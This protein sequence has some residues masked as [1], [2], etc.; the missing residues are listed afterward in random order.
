M[1][2][3]NLMG[4]LGNQM[5]QIAAVY[6]YA[7]HHGF[8][9][10]FDFDNCYTPLQGNASVKYK[11]SYFKELNR[12]SGD[13][14]FN[15]SYKEPSFSYKEIIGK[16]DNIILDGYFQSEKYFESVGDEVN[17]I[18]NKFDIKD[19]NRILTYLYGLY[20]G[21]HKDIITVHV[22]R[23]D[24]IVPPNKQEFHTNLG[25]TTDYYQKAMKLFNNNFFL[26]VSDDIQWCKDNFKGDNI[27]Y[28]PFKS[29]I[30]DLCLMSLAHGNIIANSSFSWWGA[31]LNSSR[32]NK[33]VAPRNWFGPKGPQDT[34][35]IIPENWIKI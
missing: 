33:I 8:D 29:E 12:L 24:Y 34:Q 4:G 1:I 6:A 35:D 17:I 26:F 2:T 9:Y 30:D 18:F 16:N 5:F 13:T 7:K 19:K 25:D 11:D 15:M 27:I 21:V 14:V 28:S 32:K 31:W 22:R 3:T 20:K 23:G 10:G